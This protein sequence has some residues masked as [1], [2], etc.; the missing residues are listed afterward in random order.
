MTKAEVSNLIKSLDD[1]RMEAFRVSDYKLYEN[2]TKRLDHV[3]DEYFD[4]ISTTKQVDFKME[5]EEEFRAKTVGRFDWEKFFT[6]EIKII[7][8]F[9]YA[10]R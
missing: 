10:I 8:I 7:S 1:R 4:L 2:L 6:L 9:G 3:Q 5:Q